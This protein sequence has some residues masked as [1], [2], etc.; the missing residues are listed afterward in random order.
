MSDPEFSEDFDGSAAANDEDADSTSSESFP[1]ETTSFGPTP[2]ETDTP[3]E[4]TI[5]DDFNITPTPSP[6]GSSTS[7]NIDD[8]FT[9]TL[10]G[11]PTTVESGAPF[12]LTF[13]GEPTVIPA[14]QYERFPH[15]C[16]I[17][18]AEPVAIQDAASWNETGCLQGFLCK[19]SLYKYIV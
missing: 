19:F 12:T 8:P 4:T 14:S 7:R 18:D 3:S 5:F 15:I 11:T 16:Q 1:E 17:T 13:L 10:D 2:M 6:T 9:F